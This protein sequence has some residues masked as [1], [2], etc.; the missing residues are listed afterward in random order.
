MV[1]NAY[2]HYLFFPFSVLVLLATSCAEDEPLNLNDQPGPGTGSI[3]E[4]FNGQLDL[5]DP[6]N[7]ATQA[8]PD[9]IN[10]DNTGGNQIT[11]AGATLG[12][13]LFYDQALSSDFT[14]S[15]ASCHRQ[16]LAF[17]DSDVASVGVAGTTARHSMRLVNARFGN[18]ARFFWDER[19]A[20]LEEQAVQPIQDHIE[21]GF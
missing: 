18:E 16:S 14:V 21:M 2:S 13:V 17:G 15:C 4:V 1:T 10:R 20:T 11:D 8:V 6:F 7:Y 12:R 9:Y 3:D 5:S 19:A